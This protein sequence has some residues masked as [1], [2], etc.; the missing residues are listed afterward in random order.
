M[1]S[2]AFNQHKMRALLSRLS[3]MAFVYCM[4][5]SDLMQIGFVKKEI[6]IKVFKNQKILQKVEDHEK[7]FNI[8][9]VFE[10]LDQDYYDASSIKS[11]CQLEGINKLR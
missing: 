11:I 9:E 4:N 2:Y 8:S 5:D 6:E 1:F 10:E 3:R 7:K